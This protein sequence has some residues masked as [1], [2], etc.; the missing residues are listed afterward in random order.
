[1]PP[2]A[3]PY[4]YAPHPA[5][6]YGP[7]GMQPQAVY[8]QAQWAAPPVAPAYPYVQPGFPYGMPAAPAWQQPLPPDAGPAERANTVDEIRASLREFREA[9]QELA[10]SRARRRYF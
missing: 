6:A 5:Q 9:V 3:A 1:M 4:G 8:P 7:P 2:Q 10:E